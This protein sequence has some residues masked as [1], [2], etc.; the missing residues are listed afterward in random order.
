MI[1]GS[2]DAVD[3]H[4]I[5]RTTDLDQGLQSSL[6]LSPAEADETA[7]IIE[8][9]FTLV[10]ENDLINPVWRQ[11]V[12]TAGVSGVQVHAARIHAVNHLLTMNRAE[13]A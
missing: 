12:I 6:G 2:F 10:P 11:L 13:F 3:S 4:D 5:L 9:R 8:Q 7:S 1:G